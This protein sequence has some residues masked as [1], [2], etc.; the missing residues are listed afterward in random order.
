V[1]HK[2]SLEGSRE[3]KFI[4]ALIAALSENNAD[5]FGAASAEYNA[6]KKIDPWMTSLLLQCKRSI[7]VEEPEEEE[8]EEY[9]EEEAAGGGGGGGA[10]AEDE[11]DLT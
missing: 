7:V 5:A 10:A 3:E 6:I 9:E 4:S 1:H 8:E 2:T 11:E